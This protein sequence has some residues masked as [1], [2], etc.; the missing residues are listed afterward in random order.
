MLLLY[1]DSLGP[2]WF[3]GLLAYCTLATQPRHH[4]PAHVTHETLNLAP[5]EVACS[6]RCKLHGAYSCR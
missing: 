1:A 4:P 3:V 5:Q 6:V 2:S